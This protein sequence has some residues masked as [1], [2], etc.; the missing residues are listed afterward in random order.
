M[1]KTILEVVR[2]L[3]QAE[4]LRPW[5]VLSD[6]HLLQQFVGHHDEAAFEV[7][8][9]RHGPLVFSICRRMLFDAQDAE[10]AFQATF[11]VL[12]RKAGSLT[13]QSLLSNWLHGVA[14]RV[15][16]RVRRTALRRRAVQRQGLDLTGVVGPWRFV[17]P[18][19]APVLHEEVQRL[20]DKYRSPVVLCYLEG[21]TNQEAAD[22][23]QWPVGTVKTRL[24]KAREMLRLRLARRGVTLTAGLL[25]TLAVS[26]AVV[27]AAVHAEAVHAGLAFAA[28]N[29]IGGGAA[30]APAL[31]LATGVLRTMLVSQVKRA[32][33]TLLTVAVLLGMGSLAYDGRAVAVAAQDDKKDAKPKA[34]KDAILGAWKVEKIEE[35]GKEVA[36]IE[37]GK[38]AK[39]KELTF[40]ESKL[41]F[42]GLPEI[43]YKLDASASPKT[44]DL[45]NSDGSKVFAGVYSLEGDTLKFCVTR[46][47]N[48]P[49]PKAVASK[50]GEATRLLVLKRVAKDKK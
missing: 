15:A 50:A 29:V 13:R 49:R 8:L 40:T 31:T 12:A 22:L 30:S 37:D 18:D 24:D 26:G 33:A 6:A 41:A 28:G 14:L 27:P 45:E 23:L 39:S 35:D 21:K 34:D 19:L 9:H 46:E 1:S 2:Q 25:T 38:V 3:G 43:A 5:L 44:I 47:A 48:G 36:E 42:E 4:R 16:A 32:V 10:D 17:D 7:L 11:L 20:P